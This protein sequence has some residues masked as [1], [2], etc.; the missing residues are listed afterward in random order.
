VNR[1]ATGDAEIAFSHDAAPA[2][3]NSCEGFTSP[4]FAVNPDPEVDTDSYDGPTP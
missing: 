1:D 4:I 3:G 2:G